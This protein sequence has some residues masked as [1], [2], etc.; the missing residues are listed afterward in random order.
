MQLLCALT[1]MHDASSTKYARLCGRM[2]RGVGT[3]LLVSV[4]SPPITLQYVIEYVKTA[5]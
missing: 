1:A 2:N 5:E 4:I 3:S